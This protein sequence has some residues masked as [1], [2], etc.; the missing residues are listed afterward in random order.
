M[1]VELHYQGDGRLHHNTCGTPLTPF[2]TY[3]HVLLT[4]L[5]CNLSELLTETEYA[6]RIDAALGVHARTRAIL[7]A[8]SQ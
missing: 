2:L 1:R 3:P 8:L 5:T 6:K 4:C 7:T